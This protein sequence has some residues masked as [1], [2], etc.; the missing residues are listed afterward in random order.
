[1]LAGDALAT[2]D[3]DSAIAMVTLRPEFSVP[4]APLTTDWDA[5]RSVRRLAA[6]RPYAVSAGHRLPVRGHRVAD[7]LER[8]ADVFSR[9]RK[10]RY[11]REAARS[12][13]NGVIYVPPPVPDPL[14]RQLLLTGLVTAGVLVAA[15]RRR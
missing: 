6:L 7:D 3:Q 8:F 14:P 15:R 2:L 11:I 5:R 13:Q 4:P 1:M 12:D 9:P 10:G